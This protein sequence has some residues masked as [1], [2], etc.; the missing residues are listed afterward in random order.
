MTT[1]MAPNKTLS[2]TMMNGSSS[3][4]DKCLSLVAGRSNHGVFSSG[5]QQAKEAPETY[6]MKKVA[7]SPSDEITLTELACDYKDM[8]TYEI[9]LSIMMAEKERANPKGNFRCFMDNS[10]K[11]FFI[12]ISTIEAIK[13]LTC[14]TLLNILDLAEQNGATIVYICLRKTIER[15]STYLKNFLFLG[16][17][18]LNEQEQS[19]ISMTKTHRI[20][21]YS[22]ID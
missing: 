18:Q 22:N 17:Q 11:E 15:T 8:T 7:R 3:S 4:Y 19:K 12:D 16:F 14:S 2:Q 13:M 20:L 10:S 21:K 5:R 6:T 9:S 1:I